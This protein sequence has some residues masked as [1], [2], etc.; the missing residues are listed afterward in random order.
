DRVLRRVAV[1]A[2]DDAGDVVVLALDRG[3]AMVQDDR[4]AELL[5]SLLEALPHLTRA[6]ARVLELLDQRRDVLP[7]Q[8]EDRHR[9]LPEREVLDPLR[10]P[11][12]P[13]LRSGDPPDLLG[14]GAE[15]GVVEPAAEA[16]RNPLLERLRLPLAIARAPEVRESAE[17]GLPDA[18]AAQDVLGGQWVVEELALVVDP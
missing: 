12:R 6:E 4:D 7:A 9:R 1:R 13:D 14:V 8:A 11:L 16:D 10:G 18:E 5:D 17:A 3:D 2:D 15:E